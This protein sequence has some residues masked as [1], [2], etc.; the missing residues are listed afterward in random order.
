[1]SKLITF[2]FFC[3]FLLRCN[4]YDK[5][6]EITISIKVIDSYTK[7]PRINDT[8]TVRQAKWN[9]PLRKYVEIGQYVTDSLGM[10]TLKINKENRYSF[11][12]DGPNFAFGSDEYGEGELK[13]NQ[14]IVIKVIPPNKKQFKIE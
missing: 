14:M 12:T 3:L 8:V 9:I 6:N 13:N 11:E 7:Q 4:N 5:K 10:V 1:M 2:I